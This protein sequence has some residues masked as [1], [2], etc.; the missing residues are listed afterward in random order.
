MSPTEPHLSMGTPGS[1]RLEEKNW[2]LKSDGAFG[3]VAFLIDSLGPRLGHINP[4]E[5]ACPT[6]EMRRFSPEGLAQI[7]QL[8]VVD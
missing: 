5:P 1:E 2:D 4:V 6:S 7:M 3:Q 8:K